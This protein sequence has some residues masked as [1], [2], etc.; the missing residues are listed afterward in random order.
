MMRFGR[1]GEEK[2]GKVNTHGNKDRIIVHEDELFLL[3]LLLLFF[4]LRRVFEVD[5][6]E[7]EAARETHN[8]SR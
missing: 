3:F 4:F 8:A 2:E 1:R 6:R 7:R 5:V